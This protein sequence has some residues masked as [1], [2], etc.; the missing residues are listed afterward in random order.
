MYS[1]QVVFVERFLSEDELD[2]V[3]AVE[4]DEVS[5]VGGR[6][7]DARAGGLGEGLASGIRRSKPSGPCRGRLRSCKPGSGPAFRHR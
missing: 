5:G 3:L 1:A 7:D 4:A 2:D 6:V